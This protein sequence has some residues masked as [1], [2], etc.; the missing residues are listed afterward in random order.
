MSFAEPQFEIEPLPRDIAD[1]T[2]L[3]LRRT[4][5]RVTQMYDE[6]LSS[7]GLTVGQLGI[8]AGLR[9][10]QGMGIATLAETV[11]MDASTLSRLI[12]PL[13]AAGFLT[14]ENDTEDRRAKFLR[15]TDLGEVRVREAVVALDSAQER[16]HGLLG[17]PRVAA[18]HCILDDAFIHLAE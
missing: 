2:A 6:A 11:W 5:R 3:K 1:C 7:H 17:K 10:A 8:L 18:L 15:L 4:S 12:R 9:R 13:A 14:A 16:L